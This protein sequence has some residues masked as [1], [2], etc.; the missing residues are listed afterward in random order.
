MWCK[1]CLKRDKKERWLLYIAGA[2]VGN[3]LHDSVL[4]GQVPG[5]VSRREGL[6]CSRRSKRHPE[7]GSQSHKAGSE[8]G[9]SLALPA[10]LGPQTWPIPNR[11]PLRDRQQGNKV[12]K[13][14]IFP[15]FLGGNALMEKNKDLRRHAA[16]W[17][18]QPGFESQLWQLLAVCWA[19]HCPNLGLSTHLYNGVAFED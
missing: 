1:H 6:G 11:V 19:K 3:R 18:C 7:P 4:G 2:R 15:A 10:I 12:I 5:L 16:Q 17:S 8:P 9:L 13:V 14:S